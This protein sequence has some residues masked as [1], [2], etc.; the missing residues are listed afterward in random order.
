L[1][2]AL[3]PEELLKLSENDLMSTLISLL[4]MMD[5]AHSWLYVSSSSSSC[6]PCQLGVS[7][8]LLMTRGCPCACA[9]DCVWVMDVVSRTVSIA[10]RRT[11]LSAPVKALMELLVAFKKA[12]Q[13]FPVNLIPRSLRDVLFYDAM[14]DVGNSVSV[15]DRE[16]PA[17]CS[18]VSITQRS[19]L[20]DFS[21]MGVLA[22]QNPNVD[23]VLG[24]VA[25][26]GGKWYYEVRLGQLNAVAPTGFGHPGQPVVLTIGWAS[27]KVR[28]RERVPMSLQPSVAATLCRCNPLSL[29]PFV[30]LSLCPSV[31]LSS[32]HLS[33]DALRA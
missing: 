29:C 14:A 20:P 26:R 3:T 17:T 5:R 4:P 23:V 10:Q 28:V 12:I 16:G 19:V 21:I 11:S 24:D 27:P 6:L 31:S 7:A 9:M 1:I 32:V 33:V 13:S 2:R 22:G 25:V 30:P 15:R 18:L 8:L